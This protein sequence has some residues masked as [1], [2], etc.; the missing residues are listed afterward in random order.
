MKLYSGTRTPALAG[1]L[2]WSSRLIQL[3]S[4]ALFL[5]SDIDPQRHV[6]QMRMIVLW[7]HRVKWKRPHES[8]FVVIEVLITQVPIQM[9]VQSNRKPAFRRLE[10]HRIR[11]NEGSR[12]ARRIRKAIALAIVPVDAVRTVERHARMRP[13]RYVRIEKVVS[14]EIECMTIR[15]TH[16]RGRRHLIEVIDDRVAVYPVVVV[17]K[18]ERQVIAYDPIQRRLK[19]AGLQVYAEVRQRDPGD[20]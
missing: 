10:T 6:G 20:L 15:V 16:A 9:P 17:A 14:L 19:D 8:V 13:P 7:A 3:R 5:T 18:I 11:S 1:N 4:S 12:I 2:S